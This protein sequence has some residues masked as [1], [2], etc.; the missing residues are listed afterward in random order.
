MKLVKN[1]GQEPVAEAIT[2]NTGQ[3]PVAET[4]TERDR[5]CE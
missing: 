3:E 1:T 5:L 4:I 2:Q